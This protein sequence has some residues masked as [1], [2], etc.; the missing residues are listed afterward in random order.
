MSEQGDT[1]KQGCV[2]IP[3]CGSKPDVSVYCCV[4]IWEGA[5][6]FIYKL[7]DFKQGQTVS[8]TSSSTTA[9]GANR[10]SRTFY[11]SLLIVTS[12]RRYRSIRSRT[13][14]LENRFFPRALRLLKGHGYTIATFALDTLH[15]LSLQ[16]TVCTTLT[17]TVTFNWL[18]A[19]A[20]IPY[21]KIALPVT[22][23][24]GCM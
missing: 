3:C 14:R 12:G 24:L 11:V 8:L 6:R 5:E 17:Y 4:G 15:T 7:V 16:I 13:R 22:P 1:N 2:R 10:F 20:V 23:S 21:Q 9:F 18:F 19:L